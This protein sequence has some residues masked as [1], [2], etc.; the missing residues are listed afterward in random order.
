MW[1]APGQSATSCDRWRR[2]ALHLLRL[3]LV[4][5]GQRDGGLRRF[6]PLRLLPLGPARSGGHGRRCNRGRGGP[7]GDEGQR[8][9]AM[10]RHEAHAVPRG[11]AVVVLPSSASHV[12]GLKA[13]QS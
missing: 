5:D 9:R 3:G 8:L 7:G 2:G 10:Q 1:R 4:L 13:V 6:L 11:K 12:L